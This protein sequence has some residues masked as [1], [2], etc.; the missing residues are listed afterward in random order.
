MLRRKAG[1]G[2]EGTGNEVERQHGW[3]C[4]G[5]I[6]KERLSGCEIRNTWC[7]TC[8]EL[9]GTRRK[10]CLS[11]YRTQAAMLCGMVKH[12]RSA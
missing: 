10:G 8:V 6:L 12:E 1:G 9:K 7:L 5:R 3:A 4:L 2:G 11:P